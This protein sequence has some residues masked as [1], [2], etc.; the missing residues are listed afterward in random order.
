M[1]PYIQPQELSML[2]GAHQPA[3][4][5]G[6]PFGTGD[7]NSNLGPDYKRQSAAKGDLIWQGPRRFFI[8]QVYNKQPCWSFRKHFHMIR[9]NHRFNH[10]VFS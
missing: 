9:I 10:V 6:S 3:L 7:A 4:S 2:L 8:Q 5:V 1:F